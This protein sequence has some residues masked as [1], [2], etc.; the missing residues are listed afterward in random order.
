MQ[1]ILATGGCGF[2]GSHTCVEFL[3][4]GYRV[5]IL[6][7]LINSSEET[8]N[9][10][11]EV[12]SLTDPKIAENL[13]FV[14]SDIRDTEY[15]RHLFLDQKNKGNNIDGVIHFAG[16]KSV[17]ESTIKPLDYW[18]VN[19]GGTLSLLKVIK[20]NDCKVIVFSSSA[21]IYSRF[22]KS[23]INEEQD[24]NPINPYGD[25]KASVEKLLDNFH[26]SNK[27]KNSIA[28]LRYFNPVGAHESGLI[29]EKPKGVPNNIFPLINNVATGKIKEL[30]IFGNDWDSEDGTGVRDYVH[31]M[32]VADGHLKAFNYLL[33]KKSLNLKINLGTGKGTSV[34]KLLEVFQMVNKIKVRYSF[35]P[36]REGDLGVIFAD[37]SLAYELLKW[38]PKRTVD[39]MCR[40]AWKWQS[41]NIESYHG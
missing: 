34:L 30:K 7:N 12:V 31:V 36:R 1:T 25:T 10:I 27:M 15:L 8:I 38:S 33:K 3:L 35:G 28:S 40:D 37:N 26:I 41:K 9:K 17:Y 39:D 11:K 32:D 21:T 24:I 6:D 16:L 22:S 13:E 23:P 18:D 29:G 20:E 5:L 14:N 4:S 19:F 2:I